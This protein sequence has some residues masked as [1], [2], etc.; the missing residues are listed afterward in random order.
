MGDKKELSA[1]N[2]EIRTHVLVC[3]NLCLCGGDKGAS[4]QSVVYVRMCLCV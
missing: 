3:V 2:V 1:Q 4:A